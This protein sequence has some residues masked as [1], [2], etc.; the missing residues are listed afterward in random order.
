MG[1]F[2]EREKSPPPMMVPGLE[3]LVPLLEQLLGPV[4]GASGRSLGQQAGQQ[5]VAGLLP[6]LSAGLPTFAEGLQTG[7]APQVVPGL[8]E[9]LLPE[10]QLAQQRTTGANLGTAAS[11]G[12]LTGSG[13]VQNIA[14]DTE[15]LEA[16]LQRVLGET[17]ATAELQGQQI[18]GDLARLTSPVEGIRALSPLAEAELNLP[19]RTIGQ[20]GGF[21]DAF[22]FFQQTLSPSPFETL[23]A[24]GAGGGGGGG[25]KGG[26]TQVGGGSSQ[27]EIGFEPGGAH[28]PSSSGQSNDFLDSL[29]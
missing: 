11:L 5:G 25:K 12:T 16:G 2:F 7:F 14:R 15:A 9:A 22:P 18:R 29:S 23:A 24:S 21:L 3:F 17:G 4:A 6:G 8:R 20:I 10:L 28:T 19:A 26:G 1:D 13:T 27:F